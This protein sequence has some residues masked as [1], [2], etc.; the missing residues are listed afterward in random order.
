MT[1]RYGCISKRVL[2]EVDNNGHLILLDKDDLMLT[3]LS[4]L[5]ICKKIK[6]QMTVFLNP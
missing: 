5:R 2:L 1:V 6:Q 4:A 3:A